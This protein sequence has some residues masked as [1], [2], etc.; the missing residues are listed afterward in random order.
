MESNPGNDSFLLEPRKSEEDE[1]FDNYFYPD[2]DDDNIY[3]GNCNDRLLMDYL[4]SEYEIIKIDPNINYESDDEESEMQDSDMDVEE[5]QMEVDQYYEIDEC[6]KM[7]PFVE[8]A[9]VRKMD[10][11]DSAKHTPIK[12]KEKL[13]TTTAIK[14]CDKPLEAIPRDSHILGKGVKDTTMQKDK[15]EVVVVAGDNDNKITLNL[16]VMTCDNSNTEIVDSLMLTPNSENATTGDG[17]VKKVKKKL[18]LQE[19]K[20]RRGLPQVTCSLKD[21]KDTEIPKDLPASLPP[22]PLPDLNNPKGVVMNQQTNSE[23]RNEDNQEI[24]NSEFN[25]DN[26]EEIIIVSMGCNTD[27]SIDPNEVAS[28]ASNE[29]TE[30]EIKENKTTS[31]K[32]IVNN[33]KKDNKQNILLSNSSLLASIQNVVT[34][35]QQ[36]PPASGL[37]TSKTPTKEQE[38]INQVKNENIKDE[39]EDHGEDKVIMHLRKDR[40]RPE[41][42]AMST[43]TDCLPQ[44]P[45]LVLWIKK[46]ASK[47]PNTNVTRNY[48]IRK[49]SAKSQSRS[50][51]RSNSRSSLNNNY[52]PKRHRNNSYT[53]RNKSLSSSMYSSSS[54]ESDSDYSSKSS[55]RARSRT[56]SR[57]SSDSDSDSSSSDSSQSSV[58]SYD[59]D[60]EHRGQRQR[61]YSYRSNKSNYS[62]RTRSRSRSRSRSTRRSRSPRHSFYDHD[63]HRN[64]RPKQHFNRNLTTDQ[65]RRII[66]VGHIEEDTSKKDLRRI[67]SSYGPITRISIHSK[68]TGMKYGFITFERADQAYNAIDAKSKDPNLKNYDVSFGGRRDFCRQSY[69]DLD[70][71]VAEDVDDTESVISTAKPAIAS[72]DIS[73]ED[74][75]ASTKKK[76]SAVKNLRT[77]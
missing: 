64:S 74:L 27:L 12:F 19:Y 18:N 21:V 51:S 46:C 66:Y 47:N 55:R 42:Q 67:F 32:N 77:S 49:F 76:L 54:S 28:E 13:V 4:K 56:Y 37:C 52:I 6:V 72:N 38:I 23:E 39:G 34:Q 75:L 1:L 33:L 35:K 11:T 5:I 43:Q 45:P 63:R 16:N 70:N 44:F 17:N 59:R 62:N 29:E 48:R 69:C 71:T 8:V 20:M 41:V 50:R 40:L 36:T 25:V 3:L 22:I 2:D 10:F 9:A 73:F 65:E 7:T 15:E 30:N 57:S 26:Y 24:V 14:Q 60:R 53:Q 68:D 58:D 61:L 31:L